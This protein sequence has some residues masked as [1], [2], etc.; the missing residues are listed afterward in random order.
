MASS[1]SDNEDAEN[2]IWLMMNFLPSSA[3]SH[4]H[5][6]TH[7]NARKTFMCFAFRKIKPG[8][9]KDEWMWGECCEAVGEIVCE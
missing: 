8:N 9:I 2:G 4:T 3:P 1:S 5:T 6:H 7:M